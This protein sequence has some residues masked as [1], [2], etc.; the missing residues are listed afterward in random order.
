M[1]IVFTFQVCVCENYSLRKCFVALWFFW[2]A[3]MYMRAA[4]ELEHTVEMMEQCPLGGHFCDAL[5]RQHS[6]E[7]CSAAE[8][9]LDLHTSHTFNYAPH[10]KRCRHS[11]PGFRWCNQSQWL[12]WFQRPACSQHLGQICWHSQSLE[13]FSEINFPPPS[14][15]DV[16][17]TFFPTTT[18][19]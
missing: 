8:S 2:R 19:K 14:L 16:W 3:Q 11:L 17:P 10:L 12:H 4:L 13:K 6:M 5:A 18:L 7:P 15:S 9:L 1:S